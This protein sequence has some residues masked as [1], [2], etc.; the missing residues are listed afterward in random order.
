MDGCLCKALSLS[1]YF[2]HKHWSSCWNSTVTWTRT[3][4]IASCFLLYEK[5]WSFCVINLVL[6]KSII[7]VV[8]CIN[9][10]PCPEPYWHVGDHV[11]VSAC[12][13]IWK[14][15]ER[16][17]CLDIFLSPHRLVFFSFFITYHPEVILCSWWDVKIQELTPRK[18]LP[19][20]LQV[21]FPVFPCL[22]CPFSYHTSRILSV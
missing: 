21:L 17:L 2:D 14:F 16:E 20:T 5:R 13:F 4:V 7:A 8:K 15:D 10:L 22:W 12:F 3:T 6:L 19:V 1:W 18:L 11:H 9:V